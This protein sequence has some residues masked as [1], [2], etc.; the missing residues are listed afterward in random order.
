M[1]ISVSVMINQNDK[2]KRN[3]GGRPKVS[4]KRN[5]CLTV[6]CNSIEK[7]L[8]QLNAR[9]INTSASV[10]LRELGLKG[11]IK[12]KLKTLPKEVLQFTG[13]LNHMAANL[14]QIARKRNSGEDLNAMDRASINQEVRAVQKLVEGVEAYLK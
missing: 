3:K 14:N 11:T 5:A 6:M 9:K 10:Y 13:T 2:I 12:V 1:T 8:I 7:K 4:L